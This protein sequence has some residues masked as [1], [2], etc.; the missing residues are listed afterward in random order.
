MNLITSGHFYLGESGHYYFAL[1]QLQIMLTPRSETIIL[2]K[3]TAGAGAR[4][5]VQIKLIRRR[6]QQPISATI[7]Q[8]LYSPKTTGYKAIYMSEFFTWKITKDQSRDT[9]MAMVLILLIVYVFLNQETFVFGA[10]ALHVLNMIVPQVY[11]PI[12]VIWFGI[13]RVLGTIMSKILLSIVF[14]TVVTPIGVLR[15]LLGKDSLQLRAFKASEE[16]VMLQ[17][18]HT[19]TGRDIE[20]PY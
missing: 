4:V 2:Y 5:R 13:S 8:K 9:G 3:V 12:A 16:S 7:G 19:F 6:R 17:R 14:F 10:M 1:T 11:R 18:N 20:K 15:R